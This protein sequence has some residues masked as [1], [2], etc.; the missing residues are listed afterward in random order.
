MNDRELLTIISDDLNQPSEQ[1]EEQ[2]ECLTISE[3]PTFEQEQ[4]PTANEVT[5]S[6][7]VR[8]EPHSDDS[9]GEGTCMYS[10]CSTCS[11]EQYMHIHRILVRVWGSG[12]HLK[13]TVVP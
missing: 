1:H 8:E 13:I 4:Q 9:D 11:D 5:S 12:H 6:T 2:H 3:T 10:V 7:K